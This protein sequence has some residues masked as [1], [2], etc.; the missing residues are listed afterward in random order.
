MKST[1]TRILFACALL[2]A[3]MAFAADLKADPYTQAV[4][5]Y[6]TAAA[7]QM[8]A[9]RAEIDTETKGATEAVKQKYAE[10]YAGLD[11]SDKALENLKGAAAK[12][13]DRLKAEFE[14]TREATIK[15][16]GKV[17]GKG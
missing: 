7:Q 3:P 1:I 9:I 11:R 4:T 17:R 14:A 8:S 15:L 12:D 16:L 10:V 6:V 13:F 5:A 2:G